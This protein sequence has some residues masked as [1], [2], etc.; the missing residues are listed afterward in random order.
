[1]SVEP[2]T[3]LSGVILCK[4]KKT[5]KQKT[6]TTDPQ[7]QIFY[8]NHISCVVT[9]LPPSAAPLCLLPSFACKS[10]LLRSRRAG[11][12]LQST[13]THTHTHTHSHTHT[14]SCVIGREMLICLI[15]LKF[16]S[17]SVIS[18]TLLLLCNYACM[19]WGGLWINYI[20][21]SLSAAIG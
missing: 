16:A 8:M 9:V 21:L 2:W 14:Q 13:H 4:A 17:H 5:N 10:T 7:N 18:H 11:H 1:M 12:C 19:D 3:C 6:K 20:L 15:V